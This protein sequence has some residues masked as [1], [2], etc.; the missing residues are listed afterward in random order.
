MRTTSNSLD[1]S[2]IEVKTTY[3]V[4]RKGERPYQS[5][6]I[7]TMDLNTVDSTW[8]MQIYG[9]GPILSKR[10]IKY[11]DLLGGFYSM[12]QLKEVYHLPEETIAILEQYVFLDLDHTPLEKI[13]V[14]SNGLLEIASHPYISFAL[15]RAI[16]SY[17]EQHGHYNV[18][19]DL[20]KI[21]LMDDSTYLR[22]RPYIDF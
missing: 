10:I 20:K 8:L 16:V 1:T 21:H 18:P 5:R 2:R 19:E 13:S 22:V 9:I 12:D 3:Q 14:N 11:R 4:N 17:R 15:A 6:K 7:K